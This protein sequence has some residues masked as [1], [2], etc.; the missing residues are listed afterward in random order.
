MINKF[1]S[2]GFHQHVQFFRP[3]PKIYVCCLVSLFHF[4]KKIK[5]DNTFLNVNLNKFDI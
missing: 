5:Q 4:A 2:F 3:Q 1:Y